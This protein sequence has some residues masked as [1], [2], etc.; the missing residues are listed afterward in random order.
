MRRWTLREM[1]GRGIRFVNSGTGDRLEDNR[2]AAALLSKGTVKQ[3]K[4]ITHRFK[5]PERPAGAEDHDGPSARL[6]QRDGGDGIAAIFASGRKR[7]PHEQTGTC[8]ARDRTSGRWADRNP[9]SITPHATL[10]TYGE[11]LLR[12]IRDTG[13][14]FYERMISNF[15][16]PPSMNKT[17]VS[18]DAWGCRWDF[19]LPG[20][21]G[22]VAC[23][24]LEDWD[25]FRR[26]GCPPCQKSP[27]KEIEAAK[28]TYG[29]TYPVWAGLEAFFQIMQNLRGTEN[30]MMDFFTQPEEVQK[31]IDRL[32]NGYHQPALEEQL[33]LKPDIVGLNDDWGTQTAL[34]ISPDL[35]RQF[36]KPV[37]RRMIALC[38]QGG[39]KAWFH[40][41]GYTRAILPE[42]IELGLDVINPQICCMDVAEYGAAAR[43]RITIFPD[44]D[45]QQYWWRAARMTS[46]GI[47]AMFTANWECPGRPDRTGAA[48]TGNAAGK[49][50]SDA[51]NGV[52]L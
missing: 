27:V 4:L 50:K 16:I 42:F 34:L 19:A 31:L 8:L 29:D 49:S 5:F 37:Y 41:C 35:W 2:T 47:F 32:W 3:N 26:T 25:N 48:G 51:G 28:R 15:R 43:G 17:N 10:A 36:M 20:K 6:D 30:I 45:R 44:L 7:C 22:V 21:A 46:A 14:D 9:F 24:P 1:A 23:S 40:S 11:P 39:A 52:H 18:V 12:L 13:C 38:H 33:K